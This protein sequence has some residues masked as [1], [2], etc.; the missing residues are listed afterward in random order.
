[1]YFSCYYNLKCK[2]GVN[3]ASQRSLET[4]LHRAYAIELSNEASKKIE[5]YKNILANGLN[6]QPES[7]ENKYKHKNDEYP[8]FR[9]FVPEPKLSDFLKYYDIP[10]KTFWECICPFL[11]KKRERAELINKELQYEA[12]LQYDEALQKYNEDKGIIRKK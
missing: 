11:R 12:K 9:Y 3:M 6:Y 7:L 4:Q 5:Q 1:M 10:K 2:V 8:M